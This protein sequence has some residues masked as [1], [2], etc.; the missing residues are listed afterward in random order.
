MSVSKESQFRE[1]QPL[2][3]RLWHWL[4]GLTV[5]LLLMTVF[6]RKSFLSGRMMAHLIEEKLT[7][8]KVVL[9]ADQAK[10]AAGAI[11]DEMWNWHFRL[12]FVLTGLVVFR[13]L[14]SKKQFPRLKPAFQKSKHVGFVK[15]LYATF[16][17]S[18]LFMVLSGLT[19]YFSGDLH[20]SEKIADQIQDIHELF[21]W[22]FLGFIVLHIGGVIFAE[23][24]GDAGLVS[25]MIHGGDRPDSSK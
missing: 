8:E 21:Q 19:M 9:S 2:S 20:I 4:N 18:L 11:R 17:L 6:L 7:T 5:M 1:H 13:I 24:Q 12:G 16:Y 14:F 15:S 3:L 23:N 10:V 22:Y 25:D